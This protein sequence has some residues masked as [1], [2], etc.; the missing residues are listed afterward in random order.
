M[1]SNCGLEF[2][3]GVCFLGVNFGFFRGW[4]TLF[5]CSEYGFFV[6]NVSVRIFIFRRLGEDEMRDV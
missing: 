5:S 1:K 6:R 4:G 3:F 2:R